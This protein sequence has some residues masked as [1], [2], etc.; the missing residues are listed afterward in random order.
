MTN[1]DTPETVRITVRV[2]KPMVERVDRRVR[3][4]QYCDR[5]DLTRAG[6]RR[7]LMGLE[8]A[9]RDGGAEQ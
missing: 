8:P 4:G 7:V 3:M 2:P 5:S 9:A 6:L 1:K